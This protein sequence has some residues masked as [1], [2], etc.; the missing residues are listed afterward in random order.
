MT[1]ETI[2][3]IGQTVAVIGILASLIFVGIQIRQNTEQSKAAAAEAAH[4]SFLDWYYSQT[5][6]TAAIFTKG[7]AGLEKLS[8]AERYQYFAIAM[9]LLMNIQEA[10]L[11][12][13]EGA[14]VEDRW[15]FWDKF[16][17]GIVISPPIET[18]WL[19]RR[20]MFSDAFQTYFDEMIKNKALVPVPDSAVSWLKPL[21]EPTAQPEKDTSSSEGP[22]A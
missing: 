1:L 14:L 13:T 2:Y 22:H 5:P 4:R 6:E 3:Y 7:E 8:R 16:A 12:W 18:V 15:R 11:K 19:E 20:F 9:P 17:S 10:Q 21:V